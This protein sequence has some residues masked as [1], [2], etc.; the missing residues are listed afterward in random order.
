M[1]FR[2]WIWLYLAAGSGFTRWAVLAYY[3][4]AVVVMAAA[5]LVVLVA[6]PKAILLFLLRIAA[7][8]AGGSPR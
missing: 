5:I 4:G 1:K 3:G 2:D 6:G 8:L 7:E